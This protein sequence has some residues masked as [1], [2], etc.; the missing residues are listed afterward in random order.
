MHFAQ[1]QQ[2]Q[3][4]Q[5]P[6][7]Q[8]QQPAPPQQGQQ[9]PAQQQPVPTQQAQQAAFALTPAG[10]NNNPIDYSTSEGV[11]LFKLGCES[12]PTLFDLT[13]GKMHIFIQQVRNRAIKVNW[14]PTMTF[15]PAGT[16]TQKFFLDHYGEITRAQVLAHVNTYIGTPTRNAQNSA[17]M[18]ECLVNSLTEEAQATIFSDP[19]S[20]TQA[21]V[22]DGLLLLKQI[23]GMSHI[24][25]NATTTV[26]KTRLASLDVHMQEKGS[27]IVAFNTFVRAQRNDLAMRGEQTTDLL[28]H[29][30]KRYKSA[31]DC[32]FVAYI[33]RKQDEYNE[34]NSNQMDANRLMQLAENKYKTM[35][36]SDQWGAESE[37]QQQLL[38]LTAKLE[39]MNKS[40]GKSTSYKDKLVKGSAQSKSKAKSSTKQKKKDKDKEIPAWKKKAPK[41]NESKEKDKDGKHY[42]WCPYHKLWSIHKP[43]DCR[44]KQRESD[45]EGAPQL[46]VNN[47]LTAVLELEEDL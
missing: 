8:G 46:Q 33:N 44:K 36:E 25:T 21:G 26:I 27:D 34:G 24:D 32:N 20:Y 22:Q 45:G 3:Q 35:V 19:T 47:A 1:P 4:Q 37:E 12:L 29:L 6:P 43:E 13:S 15:T 2:G 28:I 39:Q 17:Q 30:F 16:N 9:P 41:E 11:K 31:N 5:A 38:A 18:F 14:V 7:Q 23:I 40:K 10:I 42:Y